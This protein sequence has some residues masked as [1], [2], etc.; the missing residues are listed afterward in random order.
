MQ[1]W[2][3]R[4]IDFFCAL[5]GLAILSPFFGLIAVLIKLDS[6]GPVFFRYKR[7]GK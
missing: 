1:E 6:R 3:K 2:I 4:C 7:V 5:A